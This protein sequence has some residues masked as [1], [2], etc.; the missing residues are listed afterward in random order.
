MRM[1][2]IWNYNNKYESIR[3]DQIQSVT[4]PGSGPNDHGCVTLIG[5]RIIAFGGVDCAARLLKEINE[6]AG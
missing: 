3:V 6:D 1:I 4:K 5:G 2:E